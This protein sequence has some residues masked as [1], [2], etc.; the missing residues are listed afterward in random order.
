MKSAIWNNYK[1]GD[2]NENSDNKSKVVK[3]RK[4]ITLSAS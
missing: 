3:N 1:F 4:A 2:E